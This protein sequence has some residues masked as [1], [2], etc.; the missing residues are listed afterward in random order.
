MWRKFQTRWRYSTGLNPSGPG[1]H[2]ANET[3]R[4]SKLSGKLVEIVH[5]DD[6]HGIGLKNSTGHLDFYLNEGVNQPVCKNSKSQYCGHFLAAESYAE[7]LLKPNNF[8]AVKCQSWAN[9]IKGQ[10]G[11]E[12]AMI[13]TI[14]PVGDNYTHGRYYIR[15]SLSGPPHGLKEAGLTYKSKS[16]IAGSEQHNLLEDVWQKIKGIFG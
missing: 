4:I 14:P 5:S 13:G 11:K 9:F 3:N 12:R 2:D 1:F 6:T 16:D 7:A 10:C 15:T 8:Q